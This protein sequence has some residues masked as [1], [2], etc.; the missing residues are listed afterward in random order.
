MIIALQEDVRATNDELAVLLTGLGFG[1]ERIDMTQDLAIDQ[2]DQWTNPRG[3]M[4]VC[5]SCFRVP[6]TEFDAE[7]QRVA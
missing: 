3:P 2:F 4:R 1:A 7:L 6:E 5:T